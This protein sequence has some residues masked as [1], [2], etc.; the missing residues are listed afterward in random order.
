M[1]EGWQSGGGGGGFNGPPV[2]AKI[3][4]GGSIS[5]EIRESLI[6]KLVQAAAGRRATFAINQVH[7]YYGEMAKKNF[8]NYSEDS[9]RPIQTEGFG[10]AYV[11]DFTGHEGMFG[12][13]VKGCRASLTHAGR[14][15][16]V[17]CKCPPAQFDDVNRCSKT[18]LQ[19]LG[20]A[21]HGEAAAR[22]P[23]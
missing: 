10:E 23:N 15:Y 22:S 6:L 8:S 13:D 7:E 21:K 20:R 1:P 3:S 5:V 16:N 11:S 18:S 12:G 9:E 4:D 2:F 17:I 14:Q 19:A